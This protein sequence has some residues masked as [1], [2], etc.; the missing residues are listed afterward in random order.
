MY[1]LDK[2]S[3][4]TIRAVPSEPIARR[5]DR[6][7]DDYEEDEN[8]DHRIDNTQRYSDDPRYAASSS[9]RSEAVPA[10]H[11]GFQGEAISTTPAVKNVRRPE[12]QG[13]SRKRSIPRKLV[14]SGS[15]SQASEPVVS[16]ST[17]TDFHSRQSTLQK[18]LPVAPY[19]NQGLGSDEAPST[20]GIGQ[21]RNLPQAANLS[22]T[23]QDVINRSRGNTRDTE[24]IET[25]A[26]G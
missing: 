3:D 13:L 1:S 21:V 12:E 18:P 20:T 24:V 15:T 26:P 8:E 11:K 2:H 7:P 22:I 9:A 14:G 10:N 4:T 6:V 5:S 16:S 23:A 17:N 25:I 19:G